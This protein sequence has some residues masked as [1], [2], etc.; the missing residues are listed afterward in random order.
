M[1]FWKNWPYWLKGGVTFSIIS[2]VL[3]LMITKYMPLNIILSGTNF[4]WIL[5]P[6]IIISNIP[7]FTLFLLGFNEKTVNLLNAFPDAWYFAT[8]NLYAL[9][10]ISIFYFIVGSIVGWVY[11]KI[12]SRKQINNL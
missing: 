2:L 3:S 11:G 10:F 1:K 8:P 12:K 9:I 6:S 5:I 7:I 4:V